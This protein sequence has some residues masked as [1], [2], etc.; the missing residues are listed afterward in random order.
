MKKP[1]LK[2]YNTL[3][4]RKQIFRPLKDK[5][6][7]FYA[8]GPTVYDYPHIGN[9][10]AYIAEDILRRVLELNGY[11]VIHVMNITDVGHLTS[12]ADEGED[13][14][15]LAARKQKKSAWEI[16]E[17]YTKVF[18]DNIKTLNILK[19]HIMPKATEH[20]K[21]MIELIKKL[22][23]KGYTY[24]T[25][26]GIYFDTSKFKRYGKLTGM[27]FEKLNKYLKAGIR[28][29]FNP[30]KRHITDFALWKFSPKDVKRQ[31]EWDSPWGV[32]FPGWHIEC[33]A[34]S[35]KY[36]GPT[37]DIHAGGIDH[38]PIH[39]TN[40]IAQSEAATGKQ[41]VR[42]WFHV[43]FLIVE[44]KKM[45]KSLGNYYTLQDL[46]DKGYEWREIRY[47]LMSTH[48]RQQLNFTFKGLESARKAIQ[49]LGE[50][51]QRLKEVNKKGSSKRIAKIVEKYKLEFWKAINDDLNMPKALAKMWEFIRKINKLLDEEK[52]GKRDA[53]KIINL[54][55]WFDKVLG[56][57]LEEFLKEEELPE[58]AK[59][60]IKLREKARKEKNYEL[61]DKI[62][63]ELKEKY[64][65]ILEDTK[66][67]TKWK[68]VK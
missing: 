12:Q 34:M 36:L 53:R 8:C 17:F 68:K 51:M 1:K 57:K 44:G 60:L 22:E 59:K 21:D 48:Y 23:K 64:G 20:I 62:R 38:I 47:L 13:K 40:E 4:K 65:I 61:A 2:L 29:P 11:K 67:G 49:R 35:L 33:S 43:N 52:I 26:D 46:L 5:I 18:L 6:V 14:V 63:K 16:A 25:S 50:F 37:L 27:T 45:S 3:T 32:G 9:L 66:E 30:E 19:P 24:R 7:K 15:E 54:M 41:F 58:E 39:H 55:L 10:R 56:L 31:M 28:V 42:Y